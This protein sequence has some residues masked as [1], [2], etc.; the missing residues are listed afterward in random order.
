MVEH[1]DIPDGERHEPKGAGSA[2]VGQVYASD[3]AAS[4]TW[5]DLA[6]DVTA[7]L[8]D[9]STASFVLIPLTN[10]VVVTSIKYVLGAAITVADSTITVTRGGGSAMGT[11][12]IAYT[13]SAEGTTFTQT[14][15]GNN[16][17]TAGTHHYIKIAT[18]GAST[19]TAPLYI[20][21]RCRRV[22]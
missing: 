7:V 15:S 6:Y 2:T 8:A 12:V 17:I 11:Q 16:T 3:G 14:P 20:T 10:N 22:P 13:A 21:I 9:V 18:D 4:G 1:V 5:T 19:T